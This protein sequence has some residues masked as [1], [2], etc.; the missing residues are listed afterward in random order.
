MAVCGV[1]VHGGMRGFLS[2]PNTALVKS[3]GL[4]FEELALVEPLAIG[5]HSLQRAA[6]QQG[7]FVLVVGA[8]PIGLGIIELA[9]IAGA[10]V[11]AIDINEG[12]LHFCKDRLGVAYAVNPATTDAGVII[13]EVTKGNMPT[14]VIDATGSQQA[15]NRSFAYMAHGA[16]YVLVGLHKGEITFSHPEFHKREATLMSSR[17]ALRC[18][19]EHVIRCMK[20]R[21][22]NPEHYITHRLMF[23]EVKET[24]HNL[25]DPEKGVIKAMIHMPD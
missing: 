19:F 13:K 17:N 5:A 21:L 15:I 9:R 2:V 18:D 1:H 3:E 4:S 14:L 8:G 22:I 24:F 25:L 23:D 12:R 16:R 11:I 7:E 10:Q 20:Q 6:V